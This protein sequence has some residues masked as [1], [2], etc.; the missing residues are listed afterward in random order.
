[1]VISVKSHHSTGLMPD[2]VGLWFVSKVKYRHCNYSILPLHCDGCSDD[3]TLLHN[4]HTYI[5]V[6]N[7]MTIKCKDI[8]QLDI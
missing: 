5:S 6:Q 8:I 7:M 4:L 2:P 1:M 3:I